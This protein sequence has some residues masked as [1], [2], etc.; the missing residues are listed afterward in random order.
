MTAFLEIE[1][2]DHE[3]LQAAREVIQ[4]N[5]SEWNN[6]VGAAV[7]CGSGKIY[8]GVN[9]DSS[10][11]GACAETIALGMAYSAGER[12]FLCVVAVY[13]GDPEYP[14]L[15]PCGNC[16]QIWKDYAPDAQ[17]ILSRQGRLIKT[18]MRLLLPDAYI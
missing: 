2:E 11:F 12:E 9:I 7:R 15:P 6:T 14:V 13:G 18:T 10:G 8:A 1:L 16:R 4:Q 3:L 5:F 17:V